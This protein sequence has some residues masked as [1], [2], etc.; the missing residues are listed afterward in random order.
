VKHRVAAVIAA[1]IALAGCVP[2]PPPPYPSQAANQRPIP[3]DPVHLR[4]CAMLRNEIARQQYIAETSGIGA[5]LLVEGS[6]RINVWNTIN[7]LQERA[8]VEGCT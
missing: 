1:G 4:E 5:T 3:I 2:P 8:A 7:A 6:V